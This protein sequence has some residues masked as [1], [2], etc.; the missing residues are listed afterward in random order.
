MFSQKR[1]DRFLC[2][3]KWSDHLI[4]LTMISWFEWQIL[5]TKKNNF[6]FFSGHF[7][8]N[9]KGDKFKIDWLQKNYFLTA[10]HLINE[11][12]LWYLIFL[13]IKYSCF[14]IKI[15]KSLTQQKKNENLWEKLLKRAIGVNID[16]K[17]ELQGRFIWILNLENIF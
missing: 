6:C 12:F 13:K 4:W 2:P 9:R 3:I 14:T 17:L 5:D 16:L 1:E 15:H 7:H 11:T 10:F 8:N